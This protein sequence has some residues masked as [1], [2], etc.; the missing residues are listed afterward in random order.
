LIQAGAAADDT[1]DAM[2]HVL[3]QTICRTAKVLAVMHGKGL[4]VSCRGVPIV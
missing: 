2:T 3:I 4:T 1:R